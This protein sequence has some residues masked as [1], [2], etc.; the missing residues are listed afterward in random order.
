MKDFGAMIAFGIKG[1]A[2]AGAA[3]MDALQVAKRAVSLGCTDTLIEHPAS[4]THAHLTPE[5]REQAGIA[6]NL[7]RVSVGLETAGELLI[8]LEQSLAAAARSV[9]VPAD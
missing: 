6:D 9:S 5:A 4:M 3:F 2:E 8:D 7:I 1:G